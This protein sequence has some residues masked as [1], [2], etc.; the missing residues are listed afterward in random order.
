MALFVDGNPSQITDLANYESA[1][2]EVAATEGID[3]TAKATVA[4]LEI[5]L[6]L[7]RFL[8]QTPGGQQYALGHV[9]LTDGLKQWHT[10]LSLSAT[11]RD[12]HF[13]QLN[14]RHKHKWKEYEQLARASFR[15]LVE[16][17]VGLVFNPLPKPVQPILGQLAG[18]QPAR[19]YYVRVEWV[20]PQGVA[21]SPSDTTGMTT[22][23]GTALTVR[24]IGAPQMAKGWNVY[25]GLL[26][27]QAQ[28]QNNAPLALGAT[29]TLPSTGLATGSA[30]GS[31]QTAEYYLRH[32][33]VLQRG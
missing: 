1:I 24:A 23:E 2:V 29:W 6:E 28:K 20:D 3:L 27:D 8:V 26:D 13:Q 33:P 22:Q 10:L 17:G 14:D 11:Y 30:P 25:A 19:T 32:I 15:M 21:S 16:T 9:A 12:A 7:Q 18:T 5:G 4:A 31:G